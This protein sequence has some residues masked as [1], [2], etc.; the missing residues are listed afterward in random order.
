MVNFFKKN[1]GKHS[2]YKH[3]PEWFRCLSV[4]QLNLLLKTLYLGDG[5][6]STQRSE[7]YLSISE[8]LINQVQEIFVLIGKTASKK[9]IKDK[10]ATTLGGIFYVTENLRSCYK[11]T[12][13]KLKITNVKNELVYCPSTQNGIVCTR[14][15]GFIQWMAN[16]Y[17]SEDKITPDSAG[18]FCEMIQTRNHMSVLEHCSATFRIICDRGVLAEITRH[19]LASYS[20]ESTRYVSYSKDKKG[21]QFILPSWLD[22]RLCGYYKTFYGEHNIP[23]IE[24]DKDKTNLFKELLTTS[25]FNESLISEAPYT[26][27]LLSAA[28]DE[29]RYN[30]LIEKG[31][32]PQQ[33][34]AVLPNCLKTEIVMTANFREWLHFLELRTSPQAHPDMQV[35]AKMIGNKLH[36]VSPV[37]FKKEYC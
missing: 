15:K 8:E 37:I 1:F 28:E 33:A 35:I 6:H 7:I 25:D 17:K 11:V 27:W 2:K 20:V 10:S 16:C 30:R 9:F 34:R 21:M 18:K 14:R 32:K 22:K 3:L 5:S 23:C 12:R 13:N 24:F 26:D 31:W 29:L 4:R 36:E 19:R